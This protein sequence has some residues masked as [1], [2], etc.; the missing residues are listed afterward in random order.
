MTVPGMSVSDSGYQVLR[1]GRVVAWTAIGLIALGLVMVYSSTASVRALE[2]EARLFD[3]PELG[4][5]AQAASPHRYL[6]RQLRWAAIAAVLAFCVSRMPLGWL[7]RS[8]RP[9]LITSILL[10]IAVL[11]LG[12][13]VNNSRRWIDLGV[14]RFQP[15]ELLKI[16]V[17]VYVSWQLAARERAR[18]FGHRTPLMATLAPVGIAIILVLVE[19]DLGTAL[20]IAAETVVLL[21][22][23]GVRPARLLPVA[24]IA[25]PAIV[26]YAFTRFSHVS[27]RWELWIKEP[28]TG[29]QVH[30]GLVAL[31]SGGLTG[32]GLGQGT[33]K[34]GYIAESQTDFIFTVIGEELGFLGCAAVVIAF[35]TILWFGRKVAWQARILG[36]HAFYLAAGATFIICFQAL[37]NIAVVTAAVPTKGVSLPFISVG[38]SNLLMATTCVALIMNIARRTAAATTGDPWS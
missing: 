36:P 16:A 28:Q 12:R 4:T 20:F 23:A 27:R 21:G 26:V 24:M 14:L 34:L 37:M 5:P 30:E 15:S 17:L 9:L 3:A 18:S 25:M 1:A 22:L 31:G 29:T 8:G 33:Q 2:Q 35:M 10:L 6:L 13:A 11:V 38:G 19:P 32:T 7:E